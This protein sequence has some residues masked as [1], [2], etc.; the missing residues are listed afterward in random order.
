MTP[1]DLL[2]NQ[3]ETDLDEPI[4]K[5]TWHKIIQGISSSSICLRHA[6]IQFKIVH[7]L[8]WSIIRLSKIKAN[9]VPT[10]DR[11]RQAPVALQHMFWACTKLYTFWQTIY[12][13]FSTI[14]GKAVK[15]SPFI[16]LFGV[17][18]VDTPFSRWKS[19][20]LAFCSFLARRLILFTWKYPIPPNYSL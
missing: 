14:F 2:K 18:P 3:W 4:S 8:Y 19:S 7:C 13:T 12:E 11:C 10:C 15:P 6:L 17:A 20:M 9:T 5:E 16:A 1:L